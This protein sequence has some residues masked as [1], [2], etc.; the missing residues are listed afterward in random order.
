MGVAIFD[1]PMLITMLQR[2]LDLTMVGTLLLL[3]AREALLGVQV[4]VPVLYRKQVHL[5]VESV[6]IARVRV[7]AIVLA[8]SRV[9]FPLFLHDFSYLL[10]IVHAKERV[11]CLLMFLLN[12][13]AFV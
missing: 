8:L 11:L 13:Y 4:V 12:F 1:P 9:Y 5:S 6:M 7:G 3:D 2:Y 10:D